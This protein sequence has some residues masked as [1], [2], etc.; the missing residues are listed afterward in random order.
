MSLV[1]CLNFNHVGQKCWKRLFL[2]CTV[3]AEKLLGLLAFLMLRKSIRGYGTGGAI[4][5]DEEE[6]GFIYNKLSPNIRG[7]RHGTKLYA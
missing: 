2:F 1:L 4:K 6:Q 3:L 7:F 5:E